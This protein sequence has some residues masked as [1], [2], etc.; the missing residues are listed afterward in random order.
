MKQ[1]SFHRP[2]WKKRVFLR[3]FK[4]GIEYTIK[5]IEMLFRF[6]LVYQNDE[7]ISSKFKSSIQ[8]RTS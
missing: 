6:D 8:Q 2:T 5:T 7:V 3:S 1:K 4:K